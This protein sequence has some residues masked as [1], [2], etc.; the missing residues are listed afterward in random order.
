MIL[1][2]STEKV[3]TE[4]LTQ[5][6]TIDLTDLQTLDFDQDASVLAGNRQIGRAYFALK[7]H[8]AGMANDITID[9]IE[10]PVGIFPNPDTDPP[11]G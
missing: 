7:I 6:G 2:S 11:D 8:Q 9:P 1:P 5:G 10:N 3:S 4:R